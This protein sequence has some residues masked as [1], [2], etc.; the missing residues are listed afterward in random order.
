MHAVGMTGEGFRAEKIEVL[1]RRT[2]NLFSAGKGDDSIVLNGSDG[3]PDAIH[4]NGIGS[5]AQPAQENG[6]IG[7]VA[8][9]C[10]GE[11]AIQVAAQAMQSLQVLYLPGKLGCS[12]HRSH[13]VG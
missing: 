4:V 7:A 3:L 6:A 9:S 13:G 2:G 5:L 1:P 10:G 11:G 12:S 8:F